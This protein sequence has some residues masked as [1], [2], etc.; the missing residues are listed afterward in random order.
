MYGD[1]DGLNVL[2]DLNRRTQ[3]VPLVHGRISVVES[4]I[5][6]G[7]NRHGF[8]LVSWDR[9]GCGYVEER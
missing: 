4:A 3:P 1:L 9:R 6:K 2:N 8:D 5:N 7:G